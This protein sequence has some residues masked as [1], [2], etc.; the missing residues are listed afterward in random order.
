[1]RSV[2]QIIAAAVTG[3]LVLS[4]CNNAE[5]PAET[6]SAETSASG[7]RAPVI[8]IGVDGAEWQVI[9]AMVDNG[10]LPGFRQLMEEGAYGHLL[11][12]GPQVSPVVW[13]TFATGHFA[14]EHGILDFVYPYREGDKQP[15]DASLRQEPAIWNLL[16]AQGG[17]ATVIGYFVSH[18]AEEID[19][20]I[21]SDR[22]FAG[23]EQSVQPEGLDPLARRVRES[24]HRDRDI[25]FSRFFPWDYDSSQAE[26]ETSPYHKAARIVEDR[27]DNRILSE[28]FLRRMTSELLS[29]PGDLFIT[30]FRLV[31]IVS[32]SAWYYFDHSDWSEKPNP[33]NVRLLGQIIPESYRWVDEVIQQILAAHG[34]TANILVIS[35]HGFGSGTGSYETSSELLSGNHRPNGVILAHGP[36]IAPGP[37]PEHPTIMEVFPT[38]A[39]LLDVPV[40]DTIPGSIAYPLLDEAFTR[41]HPPRYV[42]RYELDWQ[43]VAKQQVDAGS[44]Q[45]E[46]ESLRGLGYIGEGVELSDS[47][48]DARLDFWASD[49]KLVVR[50][51]HADVT[52]YLLQ[53]D[54]AAAD[55]VTN[56]LK[57]RNPELLSRLL[58]RVAAKIESFR[59]DVPDGE[60]LAPALEEFLARHRA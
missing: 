46:M 54:V 26:D 59:R 40:A 27:V 11:N 20:T 32:H 13:T 36:D 60:N 55:R 58:S 31:D 25:L 37:M 28:E 34:G 56:E 29:E 22:A 49:P 51:L 2:L 6:N 30:Y 12:P 7:D 19:G 23:L 41:D 14:R 57:R 35:D 33:D 47:G 53:D 48:T 50:T 17:D 24:V 1:M 10:E 18:P 52:Y 3:L 44:Q 42:D 15:V 4:A 16:D 45:E 8:V 39:N 21:I 38:V 9:E 43:P 5:N